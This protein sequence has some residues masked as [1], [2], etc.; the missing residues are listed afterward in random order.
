MNVEHVVRHGLDPAT[1][2]AIYHA[3]PDH[4]HDKD[5]PSLWVA[6]G[7]HGRQRYRIVY[8]LLEG[9]VVFPVLVQPIT[10]FPVR[11]RGLRR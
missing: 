7:R 2:E 3:A 5:D 8:V 1:W 4:D 9:S 11:S 10:G 6:E